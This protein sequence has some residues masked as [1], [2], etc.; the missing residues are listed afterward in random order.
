MCIVTLKCVW[1]FHKHISIKKMM[2]TH[3]I[4]VLFMLLLFEQI[5]IMPKMIRDN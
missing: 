1:K 3:L 5:I 2:E 4:N